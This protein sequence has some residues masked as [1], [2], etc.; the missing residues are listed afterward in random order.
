MMYV[1]AIFRQTQRLALALAL[2][3]N[4][5]WDFVINFGIIVTKIDS[6]IKLRTPTHFVQQDNLHKCAPN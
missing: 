5:T 1:W 2:L 6:E 3:T 4:S